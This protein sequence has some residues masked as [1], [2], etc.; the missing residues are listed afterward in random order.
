MNGKEEEGTFAAA[1]VKTKD[2]KLY[3]FLGNPNMPPTSDL[4]N[5]N[6]SEFVD[7]NNKEIVEV[8]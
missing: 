2:G 7:K 4:V 3:S 1:M 5:E 6:V 8:N